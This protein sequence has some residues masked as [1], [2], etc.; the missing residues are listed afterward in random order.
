MSSGSCWC[1]NL[2]YE[3]SGEPAKT[4]IC[5]CLTCRKVTGSAFSLNT[6]VP[7]TTVKLTS[8]TPK[9]FTKAHQNGMMITITFCP[10]CATTMYKEADAKAFENMVL[11]QSGTLDM[12]VDSLGPEAEL[13]V[14]H[15][16]KWLPEL[17]GAA[18]SR[19]F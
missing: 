1:G 11:L 16:A 5:H 15:R 6:L 4:A 8:G 3:F 19:E 13:W 7:K 2:K 10:D 9:T 14:Q 17:T 12:G 18:Q